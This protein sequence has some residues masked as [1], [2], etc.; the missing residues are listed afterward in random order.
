MC[1]RDPHSGFAAFCAVLAACVAGAP[2][3]AGAEPFFDPV[4]V[5]VFGGNLLNNNA[6]EIF[7]DPGSIEF[8]ESYLV[9]AALAAPFWKPVDGLTFELEG[10]L[11]RHFGQQTH[12]EVNAPIITARWSKFP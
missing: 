12:W 8:E 6:G 9:G 3:P 2:A 4:S 10:Q 5:T 7:Y 1:D 11:V